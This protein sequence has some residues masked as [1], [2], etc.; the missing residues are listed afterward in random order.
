MQEGAGGGGQ[1]E[2]PDGLDLDQCQ[3]REPNH[4]H[5]PFATLAPS[6]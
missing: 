5:I 2:G 3:A 6:Y 4:S 1:K